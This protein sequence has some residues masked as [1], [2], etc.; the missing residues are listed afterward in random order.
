MRTLLVVLILLLLIL[1]VQLWS[2]RSGL[3]EIWSLREQIAEQEE[4]NRRLLE[5]NE[6]LEAEVDNLREGFDA[7]EERARSELGLVRQDELFFEIIDL[8]RPLRD[9]KADDEDDNDSSRD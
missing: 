9:L 3:P 8:D 6:A 1:Q 5:R 4:E 2:S 7:I